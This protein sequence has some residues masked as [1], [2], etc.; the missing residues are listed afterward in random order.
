MKKIAIKILECEEYELDSIAREFQSYIIEG[1]YSTS[2]IKRQ[3]L[4]NEMIELD[5]SMNEKMPEFS[6]LSEKFDDEM[7]EYELYKQVDEIWEVATLEE[8]EIDR[9][10]KWILV[11]VSFALVSYFIISIFE[12]F[13]IYDW[14]AFKY[15]IDGV[16]GFVL[17]A[18]TAFIPIAGSVVAYWSATELWQWNSLYA[19]AFYFFYYLPLIG[20]LLYLV[21][22]VLKL[23]YEDRWH[24][25]RHPEF[26]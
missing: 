16:V 26:N 3:I 11:I 19:L 15:E 5:I 7:I 8:L 25:F 2:A 9:T 17:S 18:V 12:I 23:L 21:G 20:F 24:R 1:D 10:P 13:A 14:Y 22:L 4:N 6:N